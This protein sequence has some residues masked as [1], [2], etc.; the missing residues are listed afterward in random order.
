MYSIYVVELRPA[1]WYDEP[2]F[3]RRSVNRRYEESGSVPAHC[4]YVGTS[5]D[6]VRRVV[7]HLEGAPG[8]SSYVRDYF[9]SVKYSVATAK[10]WDEAKL[11]EERVARDLLAS[12]SAVWY[13]T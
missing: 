8:T 6:P 9:R 3:R 2:H 11:L 1:V 12:G 5:S 13:A 10:T 7:D 4:Y